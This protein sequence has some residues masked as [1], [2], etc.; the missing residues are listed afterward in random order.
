MRSEAS[1]R[2][3][4]HA[5]VEA[6]IKRISFP[7]LEFFLD[8]EDPFLISSTEIILIPFTII[9]YNQ[10]NFINE[11][12]LQY[13]FL[14]GP[15]DL[16][17]DFHKP[18][19]KLKIGFNKDINGKKILHKN[20][21]LYGEYCLA[22]ARSVLNSHDRL[23]KFSATVW[24]ELSP[25]ISSYFEFKIIFDDST[26]VPK[27]LD[28]KKREENKYLWDSKVEETA[29]LEK[30]QHDLTTDLKDR[31]YQSTFYNALKNLK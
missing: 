25:V 20:I 29:S 7:R 13:G 26:I 4:P 21:A 18:R 3:Q 16:I 30:Q 9:I 17:E 22:V 19:L 27:K 6:Q 5:F 14:G 11:K 15:C 8:F 24:G 28:F 12:N 31:I 2:I 1:T 10:S 23:I